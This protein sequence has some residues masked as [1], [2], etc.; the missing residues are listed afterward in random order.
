MV[1][2]RKRGCL[3]TWFCYQM[4]T[5]PGNKTV[6]SS[7]PE[8]AF[9]P[10][11]NVY[12]F[13]LCH[14]SLW[15]DTSRFY[16]KP[17]GFLHWQNANDAV[18]KSRSRETSRKSWYCITTT[19]QCRGYF[20]WEIMYSMLLKDD[21]RKGCWLFWMHHYRISPMP[22]QLSFVKQIVKR[23]MMVMNRKSESCSLRYRTKVDKNDADH[24]LVNIC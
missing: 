19:I 18:L 20:L 23:Y 1:R 9:N 2:S 21:Y 11:D 6:A 17:P 15:F 4:I 14:V 13:V 16:P 24:S 5:K 3:V 12:A 7:W 8:F 10:T 22:I